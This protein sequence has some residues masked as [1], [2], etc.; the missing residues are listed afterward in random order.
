MKHHIDSVP[1]MI[2][3]HA[4]PLRMAPPMRREL[5]KVIDEQM[6][7]GIIEP[8]SD[9]PWASPAFLAPKPR[10]SSDETIKYRLISDYRV[11]NAAPIP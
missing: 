10:K 5:E 8:A 7:K 1:R 9:G 4:Q 6:S 11:L 2:P 3:S